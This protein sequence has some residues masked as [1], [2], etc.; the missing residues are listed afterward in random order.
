[1]NARSLWVTKSVLAFALLSAT[2]SHAVEFREVLSKES[3]VMFGYTQ[4]GVTMEGKFN[5]FTA[6]LAF[7]P[8][9]LKTAQAKIDIDIA[10]IDTGVD[11]AN[12]EVVGK[13]W[14]NAQTFPTASFVSTGMKS[15][16]GNRYEASGKLSI[17]GTTRDVVVPV[18]FSSAGA[19]GQFDGVL[20]IKR[21]DYAIGEG[22][23]SDVGTVADE[24]Q[25]KFHF[26]VTAAPNKK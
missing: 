19:R 20:N 4:M 10:S 22:A 26:V 13:Q 16:G 7:D 21:L 5:R 15:L 12:E 14:F 6:Q 23:W 11:E 17:K 25:I 18:T 24:I 3:T 1:M 9:K 2:V 8:A